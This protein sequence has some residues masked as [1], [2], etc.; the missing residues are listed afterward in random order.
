MKPE[1]M[2]SVLR[3]AHDRGIYVVSDECYVHPNFTGNCSR[4]AAF[5]K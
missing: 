5:T 1:H 4:R 3:V 2:S